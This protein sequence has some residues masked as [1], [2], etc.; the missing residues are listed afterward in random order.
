MMSAT[1]KDRVDIEITAALVCFARRTN[2]YDANVKFSFR[3]KVWL[4]G[5]YRHKGSFSGMLG[6]YFSNF[7]NV[8]YSYDTTLSRLGSVNK[9]SHE[10]IIGF[11]LDN[12]YSVYVRKR[13]GSMRRLLL[14]VGL[15]FGFL[16]GFAQGSAKKPIVLP[17]TISIDLSQSP[18]LEIIKDGSSRVG[19]TS[20]CNNKAINNGNVNCIVFKVKLNPKADIFNL[21]IEKPEPKAASGDNIYYWIDCVEKGT[22]GLPIK[23]RSSIYIAYCKSGGDAPYYI[24]TSTQLVK[25]SDDL[26]LR[27]G[28]SGTMSVVGLDPKTVKWT[29]IKPGG[30]GAYDNFLSPGSDSL[31]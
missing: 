19:D 25:A 20:N 24:F 30:V 22:L 29:S 8:S 4:G 21:S 13:I 9:G 3:D 27:V 10:I 17:D 7:C 15:V 11:L 1:N 2:S 28:C 23:G 18:N 5:S 16:W 14:L 12:I 26:T 31:I 6:F